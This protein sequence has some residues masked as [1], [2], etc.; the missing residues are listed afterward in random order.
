MHAVL[1]VFVPEWYM[2]VSTDTHSLFSF[3][4]CRKQVLLLC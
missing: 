3:F 2:D 1:P 4:E